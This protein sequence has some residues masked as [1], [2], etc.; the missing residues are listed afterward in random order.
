MKRVIFTILL[1]FFSVSLS[2]QSSSELF[3]QGNKAYNAEQYQSAVDSYEAILQGGEESFE[4]YYNLGNAYFR[5]GELG[6][7]ILNYERAARLKPN[8]SDVQENLEFCYARTEDKIESMP[9]FFVVRW[10]NGINQ[11]MTPR[12]WMWLALVVLLLTAVVLSYFFLS[13]SYTSRKRGLI[14]TFVMVFLLLLVVA[15]ATYSMVGAS[16]SREAIVTV[17][18]TVV[19][20]SPSDSSVDKFLLHEGTKVRLRDEMEG[21]IKISIADG[22]NGWM[23]SEDLTKI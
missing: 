13:K 18:L 12:G 16:K 19:K 20:S 17:P 15:N 22:N 3:E 2:A 21:W 8:N 23:P 7:A 9:Q 1:L 14:A 4:V 5:I 6:Q 11:S 10:W